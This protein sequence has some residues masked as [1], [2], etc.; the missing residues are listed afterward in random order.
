VNNRAGI[1][2]DPAV[3]NFSLGGGLSI[4]TTLGRHRT[5]IGNIINSL[6]IRAGVRTYPGTPSNL[7][8]RVGLDFQITFRQ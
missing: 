1:V 5:F 6:R 8:N 2:G 3:E 4:L 7:F